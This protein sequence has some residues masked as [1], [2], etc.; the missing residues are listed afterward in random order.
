M[1]DKKCYELPLKPQDLV[2]IYKDKEEDEDFVLWVDYGR[3]R[4]KLSPKHLLI[5][6]ANTNFKSTFSQIDEELLLEY[7]KSDFVVDS[8]LL[9]R[10]IA[11]IIKVK[12]QHQITPPEEQ[13]L[14]YINMDQIEE[15]LKAHGDLIEELCVSLA[16]VV[17][18]TL[19][20]IWEGL[21]DEK[22]ELEENLKEAMVNLKITDKP[23]S[24]GPNVSRILINSFDAFSLVLSRLGY[25]ETFNK[26]LYNDKPKYFGKDLFYL[27]NETN[28]VNNIISWLPPGFLVSAQI[29]NAGKS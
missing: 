26:A 1:S 10:L 6:L 18:F 9:S 11:I 17:P 5:Y 7:I 15:F 8:P 12:Y 14:A 29:E 27:L 21:N 3:S 2:A 28:I 22:R 23:T 19:H 16:S 13:L 4:Q 25:I 20:K 24:I